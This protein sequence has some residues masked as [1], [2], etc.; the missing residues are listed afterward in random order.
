[1]VTDTDI[2]T[3]SMTL[4]RRKPSS[5]DHITMLTA[6]QTLTAAVKLAATRSRPHTL[7]ST[8]M[9]ATR[10]PTS[11]LDYITTV[12]APQTLTASVK[13]TATRLLSS[14]TCRPR[15]DCCACSTSAR[16]NRTE[17]KSFERRR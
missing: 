4:T 2:Y 7:T 14:F 12:T 3:H 5:L 11:N 6:P 16:C 15:I 1:V 13:Q 10:R 8:R 17:Y 9:T